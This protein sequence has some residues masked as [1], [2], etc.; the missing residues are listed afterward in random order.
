MM[1]KI[2]VVGLNRVRGLIEDP[3]FKAK[4]KKTIRESMK[5]IYKLDKEKERKMTTTNDELKELL[6]EIIEL[7][8][9]GGGNISQPQ[10]EPPQGGSIFGRTATRWVQITYSRNLKVPRVRN[11]KIVYSPNMAFTMPP[12]GQRKRFKVGDRVKVYK[13]HVQGNGTRLYEVAEY[14]GNFLMDRDILRI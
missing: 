12:V 2:K 14:P 6:D 7:L 11:G 1:V 5:N 8:K 10:P 3:K 13:P 4:M 9:S